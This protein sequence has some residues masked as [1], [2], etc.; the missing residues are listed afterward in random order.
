MGGP[1]NGTGTKPGEIGVVGESQ[2][3]EGLRG[4]G[5]EGAGVSGTS[6]KWIAV[7]GESQ[8]YEGVRG[9]SHSPH[10]AMVGVNDVKD[11]AQAG[12]GGWFQS[13]KAEGVRG[14]AMNP[15]HGGVVGVCSDASGGTGVFGT[16]QGVAGRGVWGQVE[17]AEAS[18]VVATHAGPGGGGNALWCAHQG[19][20]TAGLFEGNVTVTGNLEVKGDIFLPARAADCAEFFEVVDGAEPGTVMVID[21]DGRLTPCA[22]VYDRRVAGVISGAGGLRPGMVLNHDRSA[23]SHSPVALVGKVICNVDASEASV[24]VGDL[25]TTSATPGYAMRASDPVKAFGAVIGKALAPLSSGLGQIP[26]LIALQ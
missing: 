10:P 8:Q 20:G 9:V 24:T 14:W 16:A 15:D 12:N 7:Y 11:A 1:L 6:D 25:L 2:L 22:G 13:D 26:I 5:H 18:A 19:G 17:G 23:K 21:D 4:I 3:A